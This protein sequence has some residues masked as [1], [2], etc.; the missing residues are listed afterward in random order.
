MVLDLETED[1]RILHDMLEDYLPTLRMEAART[2]VKDL[3]HELV[4][5]QELVERLIG[6]LT[7]AAK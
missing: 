7:A 4:L 2:H 3:R 6:R 1:A 5:R